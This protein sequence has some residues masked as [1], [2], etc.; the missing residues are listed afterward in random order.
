LTAAVPRTNTV[1]REPRCWHGAVHTRSN[2]KEDARVR[3]LVPATDGFGGHGGIALY[4]RNILTALCA[5]PK[6]EEVVALPRVVPFE[7][8]PLPHGLTWDMKAAGSKVRYL[9][10]SM[11]AAVSKRFD[12]VVCTHIHLLPV[13]YAAS[14]LQ[15]AP[16]V[17]FIYGVEVSRPTTK[18]L[19]NYLVGRV[20]ALISIRS[21]TAESLRRW[22][23]MGS[24]PEYQLEN[25]IHLER[26]G[27]APKSEKLLE[28]YGIAGKTVV[29]T[30]GRVEEPYKGFDEVLEV[31][32]RLVEAVPDIVYVIAGGGPDVPRLKEKAKSI[33]V[34]DR[35]VFTGLVSDAE[36]AD[37]YRLGDVF[38]MPGSGPGFDRYPL[39]FVFLEAMACGVPVVGCRPESEHES[40][41]DG[42]LLAEQVDPHDPDD[43]VRGILAALKNS[44]REVPKSIERYAYPEFQRRLHGIIEEIMSRA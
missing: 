11:L 20:D 21:H 32:P 2:A 34:A 16:L 3:V 23:R 7:L 40:Q 33:G 36:K 28:R 10:A 25:A 18:P 6:V 26:Y 9:A 5:H 41:N 37:H 39:R 42:A 14:R 1:K 22:A 15:R 8:E 24:T 27:V 19:S 44:K 43:I 17:L 12:L 31:L 38:A 29:M 13:A 4:V 35:V 30:M